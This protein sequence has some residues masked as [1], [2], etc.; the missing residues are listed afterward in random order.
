MLFLC[1]GNLPERSLKGKLRVEMMRYLPWRKDGCRRLVWASDTR[2]WRGTLPAGKAYHGAMLPSFPPSHYFATGNARLTS[3]ASILP[4]LA[5]LPA[6]WKHRLQRK[7]KLLRIMAARTL[8]R[9]ALAGSSYRAPAGF[10]PH[11][12]GGIT[13]CW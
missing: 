8:W 9:M 7:L 5:A 2:L 12:A 10:A 1:W 4:P 11:A 6:R 13:H 3:L